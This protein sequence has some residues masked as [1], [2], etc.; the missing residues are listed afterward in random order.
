[1]RIGQG[2]D[3]FIVVC[4]ESNGEYNKDTSIWLI[5]TTIHS[6][7]E[8]EGAHIMLY[9]HSNQY[10]SICEVLGGSKAIN[11]YPIS[12]IPPDNYGKRIFRGYLRGL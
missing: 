6:L 8:Q 9:S 7:I 5:P 10:H 11:C 4:I 3:H 2:V 1:M 12:N